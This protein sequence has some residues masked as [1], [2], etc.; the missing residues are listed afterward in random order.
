MEI[1][2]LPLHPLVIHA[3]VVFAPLAGVAALL[4]VVVP[5]WRDRLLW[6]MVVLALVAVASVVA[7]Y[8]TGKPFLSS[9]PPSI[10]SSPQV[11]THEHRARIL[12]WTTIAF[13]VLAVATA[14]LRTRAGA[15][16]TVL[17]A[18]LAV[19]SLAVLALVVLTGDAGARA[20]WG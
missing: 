4:Y 13:G 7:A 6:P 17:H 5:R 3:A 14:W 15:V 19:A 11:L 1:N 12:L 10:R 20:V 16:R 9:R 2:G 8:L 18:L